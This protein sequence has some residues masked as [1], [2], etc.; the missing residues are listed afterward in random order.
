MILQSVLFLMLRIRTFSQIL[1]HEES[2][3]EAHQ[4]DPLNERDPSNNDAIA[5][6]NLTSKISSLLDTGIWTTNHRYEIRCYQCYTGKC[7]ENFS[8]SDLQVAIYSGCACCYKSNICRGCILN[9]TV[10]KSFNIPD[11]QFCERDLCNLSTEHQAN[12]IVCYI[13]SILYMLYF[14]L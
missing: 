14:S 6:V 3:Q 7:S 8:P 2:G 9:D 5:F 11:I 12:Q 13:M 4:W 10:C 1:D